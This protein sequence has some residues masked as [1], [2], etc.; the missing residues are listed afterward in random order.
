L[1]L[2]PRLPAD[3]AT[4][5]ADVLAFQISVWDARA[6]A[7]ELRAALEQVHAIATEAGA[8]VVF[9]PAPPTTD[10]STDALLV[11]VTA[12]ARELADKYPESTLLLDPVAVWGPAFDRDVDL[13]GVPERK[14]DGVHVCP[15][16]AARFATWLVA[17]LATHF[18]GIT[19]TPPEQWAT[20]EWVTDARY[21][22]PVGS[23]A[24]LT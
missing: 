21:D 22:E 8:T 23:C 12:R 10:A 15:S 17:T 14:G 7:D 18:E 4:T 6:G 24:P 11:D 16:G 3:L 13:D 5:G 1:S 2:L 9:V 20:G 19:P